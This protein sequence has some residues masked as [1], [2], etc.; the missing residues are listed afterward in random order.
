MP[1]VTEM[2][3]P[4]LAAAVATWS[5]VLAAALREVVNQCQNSMG[6]IYAPDITFLARKLE[7]FVLEAR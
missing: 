1:A 2:T 7:S 5:A 4:G 3:G 6:V